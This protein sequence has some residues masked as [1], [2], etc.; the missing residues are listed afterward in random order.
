MIKD[1][2]KS[3]V[4]RVFNNMPGATAEEKVFNAWSYLFD[5]VA[6][7]L[8]NLK[9]LQIVLSDMDKARIKSAAKKVK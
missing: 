6:M 9:T 4:G 5:V 1:L 8:D 3:F 7:I 2:A